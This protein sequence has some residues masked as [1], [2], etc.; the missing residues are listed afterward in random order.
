MKATP[1]VS[2]LDKTQIFVYSVPH[3]TSPNV[4]NC[5]VCWNIIDSPLKLYA[6]QIS[7]YYPLIR[8]PWSWHHHGAI[9]V[10]CKASKG[11]L[12]CAPQPEWGCAL[13]RPTGEAL[14]WPAP[15]G[16]LAHYQGKRFIERCLYI[17]LLL[18]CNG[19]LY[20]RNSITNVAYSGL[21]SSK[22]HKILTSIAVLYHTIA[23]HE[24]YQVKTS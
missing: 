23:N 19:V 20:M 16:I 11:H 4:V 9:C 7:I 17:T 6:M 15:Q 21:K 24:M 14:I 13:R 22:F 10:W 18:T 2:F 5:W 3:R 1:C 8:Y 12:I